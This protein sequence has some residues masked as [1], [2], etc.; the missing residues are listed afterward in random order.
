M[1][2]EVPE[3]GQRLHALYHRVKEYGAAADERPAENGVLVLY[4]FELFGLFNKTVA[5][6]RQTM[7]CFFGAAHEDA[8]NERLPAYGSAETQILLFSIR[9]S[10]L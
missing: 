4:E 9:G 1:G 5:S 8:L 6:V 2:T 3:I 10:P 7:A